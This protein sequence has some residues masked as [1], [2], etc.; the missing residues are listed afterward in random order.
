MAI[1]DYSSDA[2]F[3]RIE[4][5]GPS[6]FKADEHIVKSI[7]AARAIY[8]KLRANHLK[9]ILLY[10]EIEGLI[11][12]NPPYD[13]NELRAAG[14]QHISNFNS[15]EPRA[16]YERFSQAYWNLLYNSEYRTTFQFRINDPQ[17]TDYA[18]ALAKNWDIVVKSYWPSFSTNVASLAAQLVKFGI[19]PVLFPDERSPK[20]RV[21]ELNRFF[22]PDAAQS[23]PDLLT[24][25]CVES[26]FTVQYLWNCYLESKDK[27][28]Q[29][30]TF[31]NAKEIARVLLWV[32]NSPIKDT[33]LP[34]DIF[35]LERKVYSGDISFDRMYNDTVRIVSL[36]QREYDGKISHYMF[37]RHYSYQQAPQDVT[38]DDFIFFRPNQFDSMQEALVIFTMNPGEYT[39]HANRGLGHKIYSLAQASIMMDCS[40]VDGGRWAAT[41]I[42]KSS[43]L[44]AADVDQIR[45]YPG[46]PTNIGTAEFVQNNLGSNLQYIIGVAQ[47]LKNNMNYNLTY[48]GSD[49]ASP[50]PDSGSL[51]PSQVRLSAFREVNVQ[52]NF[53]QH[54]YNSFDSVIAN[55][56]AKMFYS[57]E[58]DPMYDMA[59]EWRERCIEEDVPEV[60]FDRKIPKSNRG[61]PKHLDVTATRV[62]G[63][64]SQIGLL[65]GL[66]ELQAIAGSFNENE[67]REYKKLYISATIGPEYTQ[68]FAQETE[69]DEVK[70]GS[71]L[72]GVENAIV[73]QGKAPIFSPDNEHRAHMVTH[74]ALGRQVMEQVEQQQMDVIQASSVLHV[75]MPHLQQ[76]FQVLANNPFAQKFVGIVK[77]HYDEL[78]KYA[79]LIESNAEKAA[80]QQQ[81]EQQQNQELQSEAMSEQQRKDFVTQNEERRKDQKLQAQS[82]RQERAGQAKEQA[83]ARKTSGDLQIKA[84]QVQGELMIDHHKATLEAMK[85]DTSKPNGT[86]TSS[87]K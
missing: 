52:K 6:T 26:E 48:S 17:A 22:V 82:T 9:R 32:A 37:H 18:R 71:S 3:G 46:V 16:V 87:A 72:A 84:A 59:E 86:T 74:L 55:M 67:E 56:T 20:W 54:F 28:F 76:H 44:N 40:L 25:I 8:N 15:G 85:P 12:G 79:T 29:E 68:T 78:A 61:L 35:E 77:S 51:S 65:I 1:N 10:S 64:G 38:G 63:A 23:D 53:V 43:S 2:Y 19:S 7:A 24:T 58:T 80:R 49:P 42:I 31:W 60:L 27:I 83:L 57:K 5:T 81:E 70:G 39:I 47:Y 21:I 41:P 50:D 4:Q 30:K 45:F 66:Q 73:Q 11:A 69:P 62:A 14:L 75:L 36:F 33:I 13:P 34:H